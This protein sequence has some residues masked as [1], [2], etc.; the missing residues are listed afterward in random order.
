MEGSEYASSL[1][2]PPHPTLCTAF[3][4]AHP[5]LDSRNSTP[6]LLALS[7]FCF[8][9][10][11]HYA[12]SCRPAAHMIRASKTQPPVLSS[13]PPV[14]GQQHPIDPSSLPLYSAVDWHQHQRSRAMPQN[15]C[16]KTQ[17]QLSCRPIHTHLFFLL[18]S[19]EQIILD[20]LQIWDT[21]QFYHNM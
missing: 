10:S 14:P 9:P 4:P 18:C 15:F 5:R 17:R 2:Q 7:L 8:A 16:R 13:L 1:N 20:S 6:F 19:V 3:Q 21:N 11:L 12:P